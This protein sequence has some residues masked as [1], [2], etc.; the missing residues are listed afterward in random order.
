MGSI[1]EAFTRGGQTEIHNLRMSRQVIKTTIKGSLIVAILMFILL[2]FRFG[3]TPLY[4]L[5]V[6]YKAQ[7]RVI[8]SLNFL[9]KSVMNQSWLFINNRWTLIRDRS[10]IE[11]VKFKKYILLVQKHILHTA[12]WTVAT[13]IFS[14]LLFSIYWIRKGNNFQKTKFV[15]GYQLVAPKVLRKQINKLGASTIKIGDIPLPLN[16]ECEHFMISGMP[17]S[18]KTNAIHGLLKQIRTL[19]HKVVIIDSSCGFVARFFDP[20]QDQILNPFDQR[21]CS[22]DLWQECRADYDF[23]EFAESLIPSTQYDQF[24]TKAAQQL[25]ATVAVQLRSSPKR[26]IKF[27]LDSLLAAPLPQLAKNLQGTWVS[28]YADPA[29]EQIAISIRATLVA[30]VQSLKYLPTQT[31]PFSISRWI[32]NDQQGGWLFMS[33]LPTQRTVL[34]PLISSWLSIAVKS[35]M[36]LGESHKRRIWF[37]IDELATLNKIPILMQ[38]LAELRRFGGCFILSFQDLQQLDALYGLST[39][40]SFGSLT[41]T[42]IIFRLDSYGAKQMAALFGEQKIITAN[43]NISFGSNQFRDGISFSDHYLNESLIDPSDLMKLD[44]LEAFI[45][46]PRNVGISKLKFDLNHCPEINL[47]FLASAQPDFQAHKTANET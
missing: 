8:G 18:G 20:K 30:A 35:L 45:K 29:A 11:N 36:S 25:F 27:L 10:I 41:G 34:K 7:S 15:K 3:W 13:F 33:S 26:S 28:S 42:K 2:T 47:G 21:S 22:W 23:E 16:S 31:N 43:K 6:Y 19:N 17:G 24:W 44:N 46:F 12:Y 38:G 1:F 4:N 32:A 39:A 9:P 40:R 14:L 37:I 5:A